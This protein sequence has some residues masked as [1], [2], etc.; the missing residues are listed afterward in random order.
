MDFTSINPVTNKDIGQKLTKNIEQ[1]SD[2]KFKE[3]ISSFVNEV[4]D[5][6]IKAGE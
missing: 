4:N 6:Q 2:I 1:K 3:T 5:L